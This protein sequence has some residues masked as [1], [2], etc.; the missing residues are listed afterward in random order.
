MDVTMTLKVQK[1][2]RMMLRLDEAPAAAF[3]SSDRVDGSPWSLTFSPVVKPYSGDAP[4]GGS[5]SSYSC[6]REGPCL[7]R[8][9][10]ISPM[11]PRRADPSSTISIQSPAAITD[12][13]TFMPEA[14]FSW[15]SERGRPHRVLSW[16]HGVEPAEHDPRA[17]GL[18]YHPDEGAESTPAPRQGVRTRSRDAETNF[19]PPV[20]WAPPSRNSA[21]MRAPRVCLP[22]L[23]QRLLPTCRCVS[24]NSEKT[25]AVGRLLG[26][27]R[28]DNAGAKVLLGTLERMGGTVSDDVHNAL[29]CR[30]NRVDSVGF[31]HPALK[32]AA[33]G[34][35]KHASLDDRR[36][37][38]VDG[39]FN[40][41]HGLTDSYLEHLDFRLRALMLLHRDPDRLMQS[42]IASAAVREWRGS[43]EDHD[44]AVRKA[45]RPRGAVQLNHGTGTAA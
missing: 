11:G 32:H 18:S 42:A 31:A 27:F 30:G 8:R 12:H 44:R 24:G 15:S 23:A 21:A 26:L 2:G 45:G 9:G 37:C 20:R 4:V 43:I 25:A 13:A 5:A 19:L 33:R 7:E 29:G 1:L 10:S 40:I 35:L 39:F 36:A 22:V 3:A 14:F 38:R 34:R 41:N 6:R 28:T 17:T 16:S